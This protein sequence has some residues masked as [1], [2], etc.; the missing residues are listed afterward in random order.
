[1][2][3]LH[4]L[5]G[6]PPVRTGGL[7][8][9]ALDLMEG[10]KQSGCDVSMLIPGPISNSGK[11]KV[12]IRHWK[13]QN[14]IPCYRVCNPQYIPNGYGIKH[15]EYFMRDCSINVYKEWL[16]WIRPD[17]LHIH[18]L[19]GAH[20]EFLKAAK[21][22]KIPI[23]YTTH[24]YFGLC[25][26]IDLLKND[27][28]C[29]ALSW[30]ECWQ[31]CNNA[32]NLKRLQLEQSYIYRMYCNSQF[33]MSLIHNNI[34]IKFK[35]VVQS[36]LMQKIDCTSAPVDNEKTINQYLCLESYY[37][38]C[39]QLVDCYHFNSYQTQDIFTTKL[40]GINGYVIPI[41]NKAISDRRKLR[42][43]GQTLR[44]GFLGSSMPLK[45]FSYL[46][47]ELK[48][49]YQSGRTDF[50]LNTYM[51]ESTNLTFIKNH[52]PYA[53]EQQAAI[54]DEMDLLIVP[55]ICKET[56]GMVVFEALSYGTPVL[57]SENV[58]AKLLLN[59]HPGMGRIFSFQNHELSKYL[60][61]IYDNRVLLAEMNQCIYN[62][63][64]CF[65][66]EKHVNDILNM[67]YK[68]KTIQEGKKNNE[69]KC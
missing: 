49:L 59:D 29:H 38:A 34:T 13:V 57:L 19:M 60:F 63:N 56:F 11:A 44:L 37:K 39:F 10:Q 8:Q 40:Q 48:L 62:S 27:S 52:A 51:Q 30:T 6:L 22:L 36:Y 32:F 33:L 47:N 18:S 64:I 7:P 68:L 20:L 65:D 16:E 41:H 14:G 50:Y 58:G 4:Y 3:I 54:F 21:L 67:Y 69:Q 23:I 61:D 43:F 28:T 42:S 12:R 15:P 17:I 9:Y 31:C 66:Y 35:R 53:I 45:G 24:D 25:P 5:F 2:K 46:I 55:S 26:K 1:M